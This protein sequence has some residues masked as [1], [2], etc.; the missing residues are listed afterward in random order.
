MPITQFLHVSIGI[1]D[2]DK[3]VPFYRDV[4]GFTEIARLRYDKPG[5]AH[6]MGFK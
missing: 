1:S 5:P 2:P 3:S 4:L 6:V